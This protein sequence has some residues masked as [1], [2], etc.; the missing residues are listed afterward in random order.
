MGIANPLFKLSN[1]KHCLTPDLLSYRFKSLVC[2]RLRRARLQAKLDSEAESKLQSARAEE[3]RVKAQQEAEAER[4]RQAAQA[5]KDRQALLAREQ[6]QAAQPAVGQNNGTTGDYLI[7]VA[8]YSVG[9]RYGKLYLE[10]LK[11]EY[12][13]AGLFTSQKRNLDYLYI[14]SLNEFDATIAR[15]KQIRNDTR[16]M[17][18]W[19]HIVRLSR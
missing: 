15:M 2:E 5:E 16:F 10:E 12:P 1:R 4:Q 7:V 19:V 14:E 18:S 6:A 8:S 11:A 17:T 3:A 13:N 9:N